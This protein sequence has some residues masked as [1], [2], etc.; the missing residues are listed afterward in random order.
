M[1]YYH[2]GQDPEGNGNLLYWRDTQLPE[3]SMQWKFSEDVGQAVSYLKKDIWRFERETRIFYEAGPQCRA[4]KIELPI[5]K[6]LLKHLRF[7]LSPQFTS[8]D[9]S[10]FLPKDQ[11]EI[12][13]MI[14]PGQSVV[15]HEQ[16][17]FP[18]ET[19]GISFKKKR[20]KDILKT[21]RERFSAGNRETE[22]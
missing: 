19:Y 17:V 4:G 10:L 5:G 18:R 2:I 6:N 11:A 15:T 20:D 22:R 13:R 7:H 21:I 1:A 8:D 9:G 12:A 3:A 14:L 16:F